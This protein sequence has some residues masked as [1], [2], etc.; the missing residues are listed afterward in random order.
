M[1]KSSDHNRVAVFLDRDGVVNVD[2]RDYVK[3][4]REFDFLPSALDTLKLFAEKRIRVVIV[5]NQSAVN[6]GLVS[7]RSL[8][9]IHRKMLAE[10]RVQG[11]DVEAIYFCPH[12]PTENCECRKP[13]PGM[14]LR[15][16]KDLDIDLSSSYVVGDSD[17]EVELARSLGIKCIRISATDSNPSSSKRSPWSPDQPI[18]A[19]S[20][21]EAAQYILRDIERSSST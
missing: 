9:E 21:G 12:T 19:R 13:K 20:L 15:A 2:R 11:G 5:T 6:R 4:W 14:V 16:A 17:K 18:V 3:S 1:T 8:K 10:I 7:L